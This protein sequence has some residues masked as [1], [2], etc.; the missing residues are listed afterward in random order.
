MS[1]ELGRGAAFW[2]SSSMDAVKGVPRAKEWTSGEER[3]REVNRL[4]EWSKALKTQIL[5]AVVM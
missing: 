1:S 4:T 2:E 3:D 5:W